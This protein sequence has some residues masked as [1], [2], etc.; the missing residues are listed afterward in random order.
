MQ[1]LLNCNNTKRPATM[2][3]L[4]FM[5]THA[6][7]SS[8][9]PKINYIQFVNSKRAREIFCYSLSISKSGYF[10][11]SFSR[12]SNFLGHNKNVALGCPSSACIQVSFTPQRCRRRKTF[13]RQCISKLPARVAVL[14]LLL[15]V[16]QLD[17]KSN[18]AFL[19]PKLLPNE[20]E[21][22][23]LLTWL[24]IFPYHDH[25]FHH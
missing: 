4:N 1:L 24:V 16:P 17:L 5:C 11:L 18:G 8:L 12:S 19:A 9:L 22:H 20:E 13:S 15:T 6:Y 21:S 10:C 7:K 2:C 3:I 25:P 23:V 14:Q